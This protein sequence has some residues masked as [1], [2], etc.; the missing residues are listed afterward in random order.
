M[1]TLHK[2]ILLS[3]SGV[4][5]LFF[6]GFLILEY[7][8]QTVDSPAER[9]TQVQS[10]KDS[11]TSG[12][13]RQ[14]EEER[15]ALPEDPSNK[16][17]QQESK[18][19]QSLVKVDNKTEL[20][21]FLEKNGLEKD[22]VQA[23]TSLPDTYI[24]NV[25][26]QNLVSSPG[27]E[28]APRRKYSA[29]YTFTN[30]D[31]LYPQWYLSSVRAP[32]IWDDTT[33]SSAT[34]V[35]VI[36][37]G[38]ALNHEDLENRWADGG[39]DF[40]NNDSDPSAG[41]TNPSS[42]AASHGTMVA[43]L[44]GATGNNS[45]GTASVNWQTKILP[46]QVLSD[47]GSGYTDDVAAAVD[48]A[49]SQGVDVINMSLGSTGHDPILESAIEEAVQAGVA[50]I[51][52]AGN[53]GDAS[54]M[55][56]GCSYQGQILYPARYDTVIAVGAT[57]SDNT[58]ASFSSYGAKL[59]IVAPGQGSIRTPTW[60]AG[61]QTS[62]YSTSASG[63]SFASPIIAGI[64]ALHVGENPALTPEELKN[65]LTSSAQK[66]SGM[67]QAYVTNYFGYGLI[68][69]YNSFFPGTCSG[70]GNNGILGPNGSVIGTRRAG[71]RPTSFVFTQTNNTASGCVELNEW[72]STP[73]DWKHQIVSGVSNLD[74]ETREAIISAD[75]NGDGTAEFI[76]VHRNSVLNKVQLQFWDNTFKSWSK[77]VTTNLSA[78]NYLNG[79]ILAAD[80][81]GDGKD[82][83]YFIKHRNTKSKKTEIYRWS[84]SY[85]RWNLARKTN[86]GRFSSTSG[87][88]IAS[89]TNGD[90]RDEFYFLKTKNNPK[91]R[92][93]LYAW[94]PNFKSW[95]KTMPTNL[96]NIH[97]RR[98][99]IVSVDT[100]GDRKDG[101]YFA[102]THQTKS[103][104]I[105]IYRWGSGYKKWASKTITQANDL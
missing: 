6:A 17:S 51:A 8:S 21:E 46:L 24:V 100:N 31:P 69:I 30:Q 70:A 4:I 81:N 32:Q 47:S 15:R 84:G 43:G 13:N 34:T 93:V 52:A 71:K 14:P 3:A 86:L 36:D 55:Y 101:L 82:E 59:D 91:D 38:F 83:L 67:G 102:W 103:G 64:A 9:N 37:T 28:I 18:I 68:D 89:D 48:Y 57:T 2:T 61:N 74:V 33:G 49:V 53:C 58:R 60:S 87:K 27:V 7:L 72:N 50:V 10:N 80:S 11:A 42:G 85:T 54:Y 73:R 77:Q 76:R 97:A 23:S 94:Q 25:D 56:Q 98:G 39:R 96:N 95:R 45:I 88:V 90:K 40:S 26:E 99:S 92:A 75:T 63:T 1:K 20:E 19:P 44:V 41:T 16:T 65:T 78:S 12:S 62:A 104:K 79:T 66:V 22:E 5:V 35:A 29:L 105:E